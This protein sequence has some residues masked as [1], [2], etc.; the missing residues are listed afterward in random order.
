MGRKNKNAQ[1][2][3]LLSDPQVIVAPGVWDPFTSRI[4]ER[5]GFKCV[6]V[7]GYQLGIHY[8]LS[9]PLLTLTEIATTTRYI[10]SAIQIPTIVDLGAGFGEPLHVMRTVKEMERAGASGIHIEDQVYPKRVHYLKG[11]EHIISAEEMVLK[12]KAAVAARTDRDF[13]IIGRTDAMRTDGF[14]EGVKRANLFLEAGAD[15]VMVFPNSVEE[16]RRAPREINGPVCYVNIEGNKFERPVF[17]VKEFE[18][19]GYKMITYPTALI[20]PIAQEM[21]RILTNIKEKGSSGLPAVEMI[22]WKKEVEDLI[23]VEEYY[24]IEAE[25]VER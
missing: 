5:I 19:M 3:A 10:T 12:I 11:V 7:G 22:K 6:H 17:S 8:V 23:G 21:K 18:E 20:C 9:E 1:F 14:M 24:K 2:R 16:A 25:T 4:V 15:M 13:V